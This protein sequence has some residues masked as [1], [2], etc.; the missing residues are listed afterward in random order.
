[1]FWSKHSMPNDDDDEDL[2]KLH[3]QLN[4]DFDALKGKKQRRKINDSD[5]IDMVETKVDGRT[6]YEPPNSEK[7][8]IH[9]TYNYTYNNTYN[10]NNTNQENKK[11]TPFWK[12]ALKTGGVI[13]LVG[14]IITI[15]IPILIIGFTSFVMKHWKAITVLLVGSALLASSGKG[16][17]CSLVNNEIKNEKHSSHYE[18]EISKNAIFK[19]EKNIK[20]GIKDGKNKVLKI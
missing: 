12:K 5:V 8:E 13:A 10:S 15:G 20:I 2:K 14:A 17:S 16:C 18:T 11:E 1:M 9:N 3:E 4:Q 19:I 6:V 7:P